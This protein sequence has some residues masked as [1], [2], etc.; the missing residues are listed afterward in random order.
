MKRVTKA[1]RILNDSAMR[2][3]AARIRVQTAQ[4]QLNSAKDVLF[5]LHEAHNALE[6]ELAPTPRKAA[7]KPAAS[8]P[9]AKEG[10]KTGAVVAPGLCSHVSEGGAVCL[11]PPSNAV[12][13]QSAGYAGYHPF[14]PSRPV[15][16]A[17]RKSKQKPPD[18][19]SAQNSEIAT[20][21]ALAAS[22]GGD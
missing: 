12:H 19:G 9:D 6:K 16:R 5:E 13:D 3:E 10:A 18:F 17:G 11:A 20:D 1:D 4:S 21:T 8:P 2:L 7:K 14:V 22:I 15:A